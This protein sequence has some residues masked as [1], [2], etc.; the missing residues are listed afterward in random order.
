MPEFMEKLKL[1]L[2]EE[3]D[4]LYQ[5]CNGENE[6][7]CTLDMV[8]AYEKGIADAIEIV[9]RFFKNE[10]DNIETYIDND[11]FDEIYVDTKEVEY[12]LDLNKRLSEEL[13]EWKNE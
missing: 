10:L 7:F 1:A 8:R 5:D 3:C 13:K 11:V 2:C 9:H 4:V 6:T 12:I